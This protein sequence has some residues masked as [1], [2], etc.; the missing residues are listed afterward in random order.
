VE[1]IF[2]KYHSPGLGITSVNIY[3]AVY[4]IKITLKYLILSIFV[5]LSTIVFAQ[6]GKLPLDDR[7]NAS[8]SDQT[9]INK[10]KEACFSIAQKWIS[11][12]FGN[13]EN[14]VTRQDMEAGVLVINSYTPV[15]TSLYDYVRFDMT[16]SFTD[17]GYKASIS[18]LDGTSQYRTPA[19]LGINENNLVTEKEI[20]YKTE[21][22]KKKR[23]E[24]QQQL[25]QLKA[26]NDH[27]NDAMFKV[28]ASFKEY[29]SSH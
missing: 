7:K 2:Q 22:S 11:G 8:Y 23:S 1:S 19:R 16:I 27:V 9:T 14:A 15:Q 26:D 18:N 13:Y 17:K 10:S 3:F 24:I 25:E 21:T 5:C 4:H 28:L 20:Q 29:L 6:E 12:T